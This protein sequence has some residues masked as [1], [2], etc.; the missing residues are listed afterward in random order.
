MVKR[1][2]IKIDYSN[3]NYKVG[4]DCQKNVLHVLLVDTE[5]FEIKE[6]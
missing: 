1:V 2:P 3:Q 4:K 5:T 6:I